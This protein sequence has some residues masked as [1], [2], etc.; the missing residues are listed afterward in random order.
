ML[1]RVDTQTRAALWAVLTAPLWACA[2]Y[3]LTGLT[4]I[5]LTDAP[6]GGS[7][8]RAIAGTAM[9]VGAV[10]GALWTYRRKM[11]PADR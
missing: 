3:V 4:V 5:A 6:Q 10:L 8:V 9:V 7:Q 2:A 1:R 11:R